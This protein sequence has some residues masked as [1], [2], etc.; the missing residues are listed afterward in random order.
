MRRSHFIVA[1]TV[2]INHSA[3]SKEIGRK[4]KFNIAPANSLSFPMAFPSNYLDQGTTL[5][6]DFNNI[7]KKKPSDRRTSY[8]CEFSHAA[9]VTNCVALPGT[10]AFDTSQGILTWT[11]DSNAFGLFEFTV[12]AQLKRL[13]DLETFAV[14]VREPYSQ[15]GLQANYDAQF[16]RTTGPAQPGDSSWNDLIGGG[17]AQLSRFSSDAWRGVGSTTDSHRL[18]FERGSSLQ[19]PSIAQGNHS[20]QSWIQSNGISRPL[21]DSVIIG[22]DQLEISQTSNELDGS[23][24]I[25]LHA[26]GAAGAGGATGTSIEASRPIGYWQMGQNA[27]AVIPDLSGNQNPMTVLGELLFTD[28]HNDKSSAANFQGN[29]VFTEALNFGIGDRSWS[30]EAWVRV[31]ETST[32]QEVVTWYAGGSFYFLGIKASGLPVFSLRDEQNNSALVTGTFRVNDNIWHHLAATYDR[33]TLKLFVDGNLANSTV[34][35]LGWF[36]NVTTISLTIGGLWSGATYNKFFGDMAE[37]AIYDRA[38]I[39]S[40]ITSHVKGVTP[41]VATSSPGVWTQIGAVV[42]EKRAN[43]Y[44]DGTYQCGIDTEQAALHSYSLGGGEWTGSVGDFKLYQ[45][46]MGGTSNL[47]RQNYEALRRRFGR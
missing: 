34:A 43:L 29:R 33:T 13:S 45:G 22:S 3:I 40:E 10:A 23:S 18:Y 20:I 19:I 9:V 37:V 1:I 42:E 32:H 36:Y 12:S 21:T 5:V 24:Q 30:L 7:A 38:L 15:S 35:S 8:G 25:E 47:I 26:A 46:G 16:A 6:V 41:C 11:P 17:L 28:S 2:L 44:I 27:A 4:S 39:E 31:R 14:S